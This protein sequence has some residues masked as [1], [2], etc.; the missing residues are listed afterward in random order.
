M[1]TSAQDRSAGRNSVGPGASKA[2]PWLTGS[3][4]TTVRLQPL[5]AVYEKETQ[6]ARQ[7]DRLRERL[8]CECGRLCKCGPPRECGPALAGEGGASPPAPAP[9]SR[10]SPCPF[11]PVVGRVDTSSFCFRACATRAV[12]PQVAAWNSRGSCGR[13]LDA[14][15]FVLQV[16]RGQTDLIQQRLDVLPAGSII[17][18]QIVT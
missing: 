13:H 1:P 16:R 8:L 9:L 6:R 7:P 12:R 18:C 2:P 17:E 14:G 3:K 15:H 4:S 5:T 11:W 10:A